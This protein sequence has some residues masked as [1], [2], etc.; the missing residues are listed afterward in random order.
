M[1]HDSIL[2]LVGIVVGVMNAVAG[3]GMLVGFPVLL[4]AGMS[5]LASPH[6]FY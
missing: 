2:F 3:G 4:A 5:Q 1:I 6:R